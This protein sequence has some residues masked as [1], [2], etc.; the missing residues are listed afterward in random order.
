ME[1]HKEVQNAECRVKE[2]LV[3][4][5]PR[6]PKNEQLLFVATGNCSPENER[7]SIIKVSEHNSP[8]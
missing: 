4:R 8:T 3:G 7:L 2:T 5:R 6:R 1:K